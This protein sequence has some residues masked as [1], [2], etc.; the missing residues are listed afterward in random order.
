M[1][2][3]VHLAVCTGTLRIAK[4]EQPLIR[5]LPTIDLVPVRAVRRA[6]PGTRK[7]RKPELSFGGC[8][9]REPRGT[10]F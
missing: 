10:Q 4:N 7:K 1:L 2:T 8:T 5:I 9:L 6:E 3:L